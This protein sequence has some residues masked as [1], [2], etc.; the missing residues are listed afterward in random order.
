[1][2]GRFWQIVL[3][4]SFFADDRKFSRPLVRRFRRE[5]RDHMNY[6]K[7]NRWPSHRF[8]SALQRQ[9][10]AKRYICEILG[11]PRFSSFSTQSARSGHSMIVS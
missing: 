10:S 4:K 5:V 7:N 1:M 8:Y 6:R 2:N 11:V 9:K 3:K